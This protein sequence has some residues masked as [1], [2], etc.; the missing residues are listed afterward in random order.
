MQFIFVVSAAVCT[1]A[2]GL[3]KVF[4]ARAHPLILSAGIVCKLLTAILRQSH[5]HGCAVY[6]AAHLLQ[7]GK[8]YILAV[9]QKVLADIVFIGH[10][11]IVAV[12]SNG[13]RLEC[14]AVN[15]EIRH[16]E[17]L[18]QIARN[19]VGPCCVAVA[20][21][22]RHDVVVIQAVGGEARNVI[23][24]GTLLKRT[25]S[26]V[27]HIRVGCAAL[28]LM[29]V[30][31]IKIL[32]AVEHPVGGAVVG[33]SRRR[34]LAL[35]RRCRGEDVGRGVRACDCGCYHIRVRNA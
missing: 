31:R 11:S 12:S 24:L 8:S 15:I 9:A 6:L 3:D 20:A 7:S 17:R 33:K 34:Y 19:G 2:L 26:A 13:V 4:I 35:K 10:G 28:A 29:I 27:A 30:E 23:L 25:C 22:R 1:A 5:R 32:A 18:R 16:L 21:R 14:L